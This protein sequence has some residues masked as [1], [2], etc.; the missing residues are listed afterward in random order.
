MAS[1]TTACTC[2]HSLAE[3][4]EDGCYT[5]LF[6]PEHRDLVRY[7]ACRYAPAIDCRACSD[8]SLPAMHREPCD[9]DCADRWAR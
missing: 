8:C 6:D 4:G 7:C 3:H 5:F 1:N 9:C 2:E